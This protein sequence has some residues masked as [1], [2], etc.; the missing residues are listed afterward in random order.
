MGL[1]VDRS[2]LNVGQKFYHVKGFEFLLK[3]VVRSSGSVFLS[4]ASHWG[5]PSSEEFPCP[6]FVHSRSYKLCMTVTDFTTACGRTRQT[7]QSNETR[8]PRMLSLL[9][10]LELFIR[11]KFF[12]YFSL[13]CLKGSFSLRHSVFILREQRFSC[14]WHITASLFVCSV[15][16]LF[17]FRLM[18]LHVTA[19]GIVC[20]TQPECLLEVAVQ[21]HFMPVCCVVFL[22]FVWCIVYNWTHMYCLVLRAGLA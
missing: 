18:H 20:T 10:G 17:F 13:C 19:I 8:R 14:C 4:A 21:E 5:L 11:V 12:C 22:F 9:S 16:F 6:S 15:V 3:N 2:L 7:K 1:G